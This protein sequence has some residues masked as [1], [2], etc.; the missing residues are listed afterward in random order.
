MRSLLRLNGG[1]CLDYFGRYRT[2]ECFY[3]L[4]IPQGEIMACATT[5]TQTVPNE[6]EFKA[7]MRIG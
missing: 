6:P 5:A 7:S 2:V 1:L 4:R 3:S